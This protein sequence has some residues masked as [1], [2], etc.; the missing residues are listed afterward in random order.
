VNARTAIAA[1]FSVIAIAAFLLEVVSWHATGSIGGRLHLSGPCTVQFN[2][3]TQEESTRG[4][5]PGD[6]VDLRN[7][8]RLF[9]ADTLP[10]LVTP[11][12][13]SGA[14][15]DTVA[16]PI[17]R[18]TRQVRV[19]ETLR[20]HGSFGW[21]I[22]NVGFKLFFLLFG[23]FVL[24][25]GKDT[26]SL[27]LGV[28]CLVVSFA[29]PEAWFGAVAAG[30][31]LG[32]ALMAA[33]LFSIAPVLLYFII[34]AVVR[35]LVPAS[36]VWLTRIAL[37]LCAAPA[38][39]N[40]TVNTLAQIDSGCGLLVIRSDVGLIANQA[41]ILLFFVL[42]YG[43]ARGI[44]RQRIRWVF[45]AFLIS[46]VGIV[47]HWINP[48]VP[49][50]VQFGV[51]WLTVMCFPLG[52]AYAVLRHRIIDVSFVLNR[53]LLYTVL[54]TLTVG[55]L[56]LLENLLNN[57]A[58]GRGIGLAVSVLVALSIGLSF[59]VLRER[60]HSSIN[61]LLF[62]RKHE[63]AVALNRFMD[64]A[65]FIQNSNA[66]VTRA[67]REICTGM[68]TDD[69]RFYQTSSDG[70]HRLGE[71]AGPG[72]EELLDAD[73]PAF[74]KLRRMESYVDLSAVSSVLGSAGYAFPL[75]ARGESF[76]ALVC[77]RRADDEGYAPDERDLL[78]HVARE[79][80]AELFMMRAREEEKGRE[81]TDIDARRI[82]ELE[83]ENRRLKEALDREQ[84]EERMMPPDER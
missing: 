20:Q 65:P 17:V 74:V 22:A 68:A 7:A 71:P 70:Y 80:A 37:F 5:R 43:R 84:A 13:Y 67:S 11:T 38:L 58:V 57:F 35:G 41:I 44:Q 48:V 72:R 66:L 33:T 79:V 81:D 23:A 9:R 8:D 63:T 53:A 27:V 18:G 50:P 54:T 32:L 30:G 62:R 55:L 39:F 60:L 64:E 2:A 49:H 59:H 77:G 26:A 1:T 69:V 25:R 56:V 61:R 45:W 40:Q 83:D 10:N 4:I 36:L 82:R 31:R 28:W 34:E 73:D 51:E 3:T 29:L 42:A 16:F 76:G 14:V 19:V 24:F 15:G 75:F 52:T 78:R 47:M 21:L 12:V 46:R 6:V